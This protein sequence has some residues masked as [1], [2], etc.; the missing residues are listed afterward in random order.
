[1]ELSTSTVN[2]F[3]ISR[4]FIYIALGIVIIVVGLYLYKKIKFKKSS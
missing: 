4:S 3:G 1:M 2:A